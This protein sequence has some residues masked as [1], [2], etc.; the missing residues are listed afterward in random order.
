MEERIAFFPAS[1]LW[2]IL[3]EPVVMTLLH[4]GFHSIMASPNIDETQK[5]VGSIV[6]FQ[7]PLAEINLIN[8]PNPFT[9]LDKPFLMV[10]V[11]GVIREGSINMQ[12]IAF[13]NYKQRTAVDV[14]RNY[15]QFSSSLRDSTRQITYQQ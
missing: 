2:E 11:I 6:C 7:A 1:K 15:R 10:W 12:Q 14:E 8:Y 5:Q 13:Y 9:L 3:E 4:N